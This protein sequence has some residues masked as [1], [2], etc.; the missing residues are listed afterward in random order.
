MLVVRVRGLVPR[1][2]WQRR[3]DEINRVRGTSLAA[4]GVTI[5]K[6]FLHISYEEQRERLLA[7]LDDPDKHWKFNPGDIEDRALG[8]ST[9]RR[10]RMRCARCSHRRRALV[11]RA[12]RPQVVPQLG[13]EQAA[14]RALEA[15]DPH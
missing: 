4:D 5:V 11:R 7:R 6:V 15:M 8:P 10:T 3:Y 1:K 12:G 13:G 14:A 2:V 9:R